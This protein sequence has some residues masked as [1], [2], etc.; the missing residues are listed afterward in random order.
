MSIG[1]M[2]AMEKAKKKAKWFQCKKC[3]CSFN[4][5]E[6]FLNFCPNCGLQ[7]HTIIDKN[8]RYG[9][10]D[11]TTGAVKS[12]GFCEYCRPPV[13]AYM[14]VNYSVCQNCG[15]ELSLKDYGLDE[16]GQSTEVRRRGEGK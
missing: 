9:L 12:G 14:A 10:P 2:A 13:G 3:M 1:E 4:V 7:M 6:D 5:E 11:W 16:N 8:T 15:R